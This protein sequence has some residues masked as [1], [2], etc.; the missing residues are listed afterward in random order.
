[1]LSNV[2][3]GSNSVADSRPSTRSYLQ[4]RQSSNVYSL[5]TGS[6]G[7][8][9]IIVNATLVNNLN[10]M[11]SGGSINI[12]ILSFTPSQT[13]IYYISLNVV[14]TDAETI[15]GFSWDNL[16]IIDLTKMFGSDAGIVSAL[17]LSSVSEITTDKA[18]QAFERMFPSSYYAYDEG[19]LLSFN[20][21]DIQTT[22][23][24]Q[25]DNSKQTENVHVLADQKY[26]IK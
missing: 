2:S 25:Y 26:R 5:G 7:G 16:K 11:L 1:M 17:G 6:I 10:I 18:V 24:N 12:S 4:V 20:P 13:H 14:T 21:T 22:G 9:S 3:S 15:G 19:S 8:H 23:F